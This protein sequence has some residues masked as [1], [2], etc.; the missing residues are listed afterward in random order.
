MK[1]ETFI[2]KRSDCK[3]LIYPY[4]DNKSE[5]LSNSFVPFCLTS[6][7]YNKKSF[8]WTSEESMTKK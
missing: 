4:M 5:V 8:I 1:T 7:E 3:I 6:S 2:S